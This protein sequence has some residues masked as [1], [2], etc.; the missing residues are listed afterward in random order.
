[1]LATSPVAP[2]QMHGP[3]YGSVSSGSDGVGACG[4]DTPSH[5]AQ[6][7]MARTRSVPAQAA[8]IDINDEAMAAAVGG[9][10]FASITFRLFKLAPGALEGTPEDYGHVATYQARPPARRA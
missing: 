9:A 8:P 3:H 2:S 7:G 1:M 5:V 6:T 10:R 4:P